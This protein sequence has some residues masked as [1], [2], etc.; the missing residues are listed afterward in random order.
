MFEEPRETKHSPKGSL[1]FICLLGFI[2]CAIFGIG[3][4]LGAIVMTFLSVISLFQNANQNQVMWK[5]WKYFIN[6]VVASFGFMLGMISPTLGFGLLAIYFSLA[7][8]L[9]DDDILLK[10]IRRSFNHL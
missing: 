10:V 4:F 5:L 8:Q 1:R 9:A 7:S 3:M 6:T 2:F